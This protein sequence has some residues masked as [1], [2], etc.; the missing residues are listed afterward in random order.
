MSSDENEYSTYEEYK[1]DMDYWIKV[2]EGTRNDLLATKND[3]K[4]S[5][6]NYLK[7]REWMIPNLIPFESVVVLAGKTGT[8]KTFLALYFSWC[9]ANGISVLK[10]DPSKKY[11]VKYLPLEDAQQ[12]VP[13]VDAL[14]NV[15]AEV[16]YFLSDLTFNRSSLSIN[17][18]NFEHKYRIEKFA[19][20]NDLIVIDTLSYCLPDGDES[21]GNVIR[22]TMHWIARCARNGKCSFLLLHHTTK[23]SN[24][25]LRGSSEIENIASTVLITDGKKLRVKKQRQGESGQSFHYEMRTIETTNGDTTLLPKFEK[26]RDQLTDRQKAFLTFLENLPSKS[27]T[28][29]EILEWYR[30][31]YPEVKEATSR[32]HVEREL[33]R[34]C[35]W[36]LVTLRKHLNND[37][38]GINDGL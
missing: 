22:E 14:K 18:D 3:F 12:L 32:K 10:S 9:L 37:K 15:F 11:K 16:K 34:L 17:E 19:E 7:A 25:N 30:K 28:R 20:E 36:E 26:P 2:S 29:A 35:D 13:R 31:E 38:Y 33:K 21:K 27:A 8:H 6:F 24:E 1:K 5:Q 4:L 23:G